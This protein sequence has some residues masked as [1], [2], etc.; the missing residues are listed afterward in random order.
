[1]KVKLGETYKDKIHGTEGIA[2][3]RITYLTGC[4][5]VNL[6]WREGSKIHDMWVDEKRLVGSTV[7]TPGGPGKVPPN[8]AP[9]NR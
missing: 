3:A 9:K 6:E 8:R 1:M 4:S 5:S 7:K 2:V